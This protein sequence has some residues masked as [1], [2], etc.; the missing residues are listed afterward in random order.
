MKKLIVKGTIPKNIPCIVNTFEEEYELYLRKA[1]KYWRTR[2]GF[3]LEFDSTLSDLIESHFIYVDNEKL[4]S[5]IKKKLN[6]IEE[7]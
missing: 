3:S 2:E 4:E 5:I 7:V 6:V 1:G